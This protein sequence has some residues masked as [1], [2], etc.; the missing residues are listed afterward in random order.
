MADTFDTTIK[1]KAGSTD[2]YVMWLVDEDTGETLPLDGITSPKIT[3][4]ARRDDA[5]NFLEFTGTVNTATR[6][7]AFAVNPAANAAPGHY[8]WQLE[9]TDAGTLVIADDYFP[10][11]LQTP[12]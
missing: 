11:I 12:L 5:V 7:F 6:K 10:F 2:T 9:Y 8:L 1:I 4:K 3:V